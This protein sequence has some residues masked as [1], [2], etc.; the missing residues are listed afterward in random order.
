MQRSVVLCSGG[1][2]SAVLLALAQEA[3]PVLVVHARYEHP[4]AEREARTLS[5]LLSRFDR[6]DCLVIDLPRAAG[7]RRAVDASPEGSPTAERPLDTPLPGLMTSLLGIGCVVA[8]S[9]SAPKLW[10]GLCEAGPTPGGNDDT[11][12]EQSREYA[13]LME[14]ALALATPDNPLSIEAPLIDLSRGDIVKLARRLE[15]PLKHTWSCRVRGDTPCQACRGCRQRARAF[16]DATI[17]DPVLAHALN[18]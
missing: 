3:S 11:D 4:A 2:N 7:F 13:Q 10:V 12:P 1:L 15:V 14:H 6:T 8:A 9:I 17:A 16:L 18:G 5:K